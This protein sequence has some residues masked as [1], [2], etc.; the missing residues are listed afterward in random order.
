MRINARLDQAR[1]R[2]LREIQSATGLTTSEVVKQG[3]DLVHRECVREPKARL[4]ALLSSGFVGCADGPARPQAWYWLTPG[5]GWPWP[6]A[7]TIGTKLRLV[8][9]VSSTTNSSP[10]GLCSPRPATCCSPASDRHR[11]CICWP[12]L[13]TAHSAL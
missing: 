8:S 7:G 2:K 11:S 12:T 10:P 6:I 1:E 4:E 5:I 3:L 9:L 13:Q